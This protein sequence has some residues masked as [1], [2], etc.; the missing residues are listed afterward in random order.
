M[1]VLH[2]FFL[3]YHGVFQGFLVLPVIVCKQLHVP[4]CDGNKGITFQPGIYNVR[5]RGL[6]LLEFSLMVV[7]G[8]HCDSK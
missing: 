6:Y 7:L 2:E 8:V 4:G 1:Y 5:M 3:T